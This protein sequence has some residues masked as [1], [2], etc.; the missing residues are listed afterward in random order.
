MTIQPQNNNLIYLI[1]PID[2][3]MLIDYLFYLFQEIIILIA[4]IP[5]QIIM[6][7]KLQLMTLMV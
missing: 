5:F 7:Q 2:P 4:G 6:H 1:D 3:Q